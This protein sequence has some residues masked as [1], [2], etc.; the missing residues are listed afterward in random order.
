MMRYTLLLSAI[1]YIITIDISWAQLTINL[2]SFGS[3]QGEINSTVSNVR[4]FIGIP[5]AQPPI[6]PLRFKS[7]VPLNNSLSNGTIYN[8][9]AAAHLGGFP[10]FDCMQ[11]SFTN[12]DLIY[13]QEDCLYLDIYLPF[14]ITNGSLLPVVIYIYGGG[15]QTS[16]P[17]SPSQ[18]V[19]LYQN[20]IYVAIRYRINVFGFMASTALSASRLGPIQSSGVQGFEDQQMAIKWVYDNIQFFGGNSSCITLQGHSAGA[21]SVC[22]HLVAPASQGLFQRAITE[23]AG[24]DVTELS[25]EDAETMGNQISSYFCHSSSN[26]ISCL[27]SIDAITL[28]QYSKS[29]GYVSFFGNGFHPPIDGLVFPD[30]IINLLQQ[31]RFPA[32]ISLLAG[33]TSAEM[34]LFISAGFEPGWQLFNVSQSVLSGWVE[35]LSNGQSAY[36]NTTYNPYVN[37]YVPSTLINYYGLTDATSTGVIQCAVRRTAAY[38]DNNGNGSVYLYSFNYIPVSSP[39]ASLSQSVHG[40]ELP[41]VFNMANSSAFTQTIFPVSSFNPDEQ[42]LASAMSLLWIRFAINGNPNTP[43]FIEDC[44]PIITQM[45]RIGG[46]PN[47]A[48]NSMSNSSRYLVFAN[49]A[50]GNSSATIMLATNGYHSPTCAAWDAVVSN[51]NITKRCAAGYSGVNCTI[52]SDSRIN[53]ASILIF[54]SIAL[55]M[56]FYNV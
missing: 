12:P 19:S 34:A 17:H 8:A 40:Q 45:K 36:L 6:G 44:N 49:T 56:F 7:P 35:S 29:Q 13:G 47:Y 26:V 9:T 39:F 54:S 21:E 31:K 4:Q 3:V 53:T 30:T 1:V 2:P 46:W 37:P 16:D 24:C 22:L 25:L 52:T 41:F 10:L 55:T 23:S 20:I 28:L 27:Q 14:N 32:N 42:I 11:F 43:I 5:F 18:L 50:L 38:L 15:L 33:T 48:T 51:I